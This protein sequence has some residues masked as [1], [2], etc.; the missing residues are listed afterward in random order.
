MSYVVIGRFSE[1]GPRGPD[2]SP[3]RLGGGGHVSALSPGLHTQAP[4]GTH[5]GAGGED[6]QE[7]YVTGANRA[8]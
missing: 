3:E 6:P 8:T 4:S 2:R 1:L 7:W 5:R